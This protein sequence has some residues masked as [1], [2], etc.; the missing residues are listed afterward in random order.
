MSLDAPK[1]IPTTALGY[2]DNGGTFLEEANWSAS[3]SEMFTSL[4][5]HLRTESSLQAHCKLAA[6]LFGVHRKLT[7]SSLKAH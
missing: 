6:S 3:P 4:S 1:V 5:L 7:S 2:F